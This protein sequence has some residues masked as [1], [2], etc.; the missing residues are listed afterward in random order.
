MAQLIKTTHV[1]FLDASGT[2]FVSISNV[3]GN[4]SEEVECC[5]G[6]QNLAMSCEMKD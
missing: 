6:Q 1:L 2:N 3:S 4:T 5:L